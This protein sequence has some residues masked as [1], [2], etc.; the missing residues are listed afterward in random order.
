MKNN[1][2][3][4]DKSAPT[5]IEAQLSVSI[6]LESSLSKATSEVENFPNVENE[7][8]AGLAQPCIMDAMVDIE[9]LGIKNNSVVLSIAVIIFDRLDAAKYIGHSLTTGEQ[10]RSLT[11]YTHSFHTPVSMLDCLASG[12]IID[13]G[14]A[15]WWKG[16]KDRSQLV[17]SMACTE[18]LATTMMR[19]KEFLEYGYGSIWAK[20]PSFDISILRSLSS[21]VGID[22][23]I[24]FRKER[25]VRTEIQDYPQFDV[26]QVSKGMTIYN[27]HGAEIGLHDPV[28]DAIIQLQAV[29]EVY[30]AKGLYKG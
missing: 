22:L 17:D 21:S 9:T 24:D 13:K 2:T 7:S 6:E 8:E 23:G 14:T 27:K 12:S 28:Y 30:A 5:S 4:N 10:C 18:S 20:S 3:T 19:L 26:R 15:E 16:K 11:N 29:Q 1:I 25:D